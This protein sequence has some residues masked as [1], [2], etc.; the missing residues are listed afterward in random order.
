MKYIVELYVTHTDKEYWEIEVP[1]GTDIND[2]T[3]QLHDDPFMVM[4]DFEGDIVDSDHVETL[5]M[6]YNS[7]YKAEEDNPP[8]NSDL[9]DDVSP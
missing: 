1:E 7:M 6:T 2:L 4:L 8:S 9:E 5:N 3:H